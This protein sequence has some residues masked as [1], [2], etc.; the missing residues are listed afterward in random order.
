MNLPKV[1]LIHPDLDFQFR[2]VANSEFVGGLPSV[3]QAFKL[4]PL[5]SQSAG[6]G[7]AH[8]DVEHVA[9]MGKGNIL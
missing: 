3:I 7:A 1:G 4:D 2:P 9:V 5:M 8:H 6:K